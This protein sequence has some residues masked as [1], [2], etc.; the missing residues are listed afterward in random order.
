MNIYC[1]CIV[2][3]IGEGREGG[4]EGGGE[5]G[6]RFEDTYISRALFKLPFLKV[7]TSRCQSC[8]IRFF[9]AECACTM[10]V[11]SITCMLTGSSHT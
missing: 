5:A 8:I 2:G 11:L 10:Y 9:Q 4:R 1:R 6:K 7:H 3:A